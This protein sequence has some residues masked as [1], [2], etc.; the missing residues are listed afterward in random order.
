MVRHAES[1]DLLI[2]G[3]LG[4][5]LALLYLPLI[6]PILLSLAPTQAGESGFFFHAYTDIG[7]NPVL[8]AAIATTVETAL[9]ASILTPLLGLL[10][11]VAIRE[12]RAPRLILFLMLL[13]LFI[14]GISLGLAV[15]FFFRQL[16]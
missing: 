8:V 16:G 15:G 3:G 5:V 14:P 1:G 7:R 13:P 11:A 9:V 10:A 2:W 4:A 12:L 6:P